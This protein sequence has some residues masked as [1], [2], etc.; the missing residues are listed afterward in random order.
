MPLTEAW[1]LNGDTWAVFTE[2]AECVEAAREAGLKLMAEYY[3]NGRAIAW[4]FTGPKEAVKGVAKANKANTG[5][6]KANR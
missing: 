1:E 6:G 3:R 2:E 5:S 4:Q